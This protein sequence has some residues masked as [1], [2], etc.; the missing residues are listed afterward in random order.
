MKKSEDLRGPQDRP[1]L[2]V[3]NTRS[4]GADGEPVSSEE[5]GDP[6]HHGLYEGAPGPER[7]VLEKRRDRQRRH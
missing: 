6:L 4:V 5:I 1:D 7:T 2:T 3:V